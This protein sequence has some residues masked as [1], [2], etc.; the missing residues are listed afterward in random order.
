MLSNAISEDQRK[1][2][3]SDSDLV[4]SVMISTY[5]LANKGYLVSFF[6][7]GPDGN[8]EVYDPAF[9]LDFEA[10][11]L[12]NFLE[13]NSILLPKGC[14]YLPPLA[15]GNFIRSLSSGASFFE[16][17]LLA[18]SSPMQGLLLVKINEDSFFD[19]EQKEED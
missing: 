14:Y 18:P 5:P 13:F 2:S 10:S 11:K 8:F 16:M 15:L 17:T 7:D 3:V 12:A 4:V 1:S 9:S 6:T 19:H